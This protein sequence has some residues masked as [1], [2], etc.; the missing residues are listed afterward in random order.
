MA[1]L[2]SN[3]TFVFLSIAAFASIFLLPLLARAAFGGDAPQP[4]LVGTVLFGFVAF[5]CCIL[6]LLI[7]ALFGIAQRL[8]ILGR[9]AVAAGC[10]GPVDSASARRG[11]DLATLAA[12]AIWLAG[13]GVAAAGVLGL[14]VA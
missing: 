1:M 11:A 6:P 3:R 13:V 5:V 12:W 8:G 2:P 10:Q 9:F 7:R 4:V 14:G